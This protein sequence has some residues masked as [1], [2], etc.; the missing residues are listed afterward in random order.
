[1]VRK[2]GATCT[3]TGYPFYKLKIKEHSSNSLDSKTLHTL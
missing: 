1:M 2:F 3:V